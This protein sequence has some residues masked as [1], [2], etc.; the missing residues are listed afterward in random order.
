MTTVAYPLYPLF[1][2]QNPWYIMLYGCLPVAVIVGYVG[3]L[4]YRR[5]RGRGKPMT[6][7]EI[8]VAIAGL[9]TRVTVTHDAQKQLYTEMM[10]LLKLFVYLDDVSQIAHRGRNVLSGSN[11]T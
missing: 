8:K 11:L 4:V 3:W 10:R 5:V 2:W 9:S 6:R 1:W 7:D